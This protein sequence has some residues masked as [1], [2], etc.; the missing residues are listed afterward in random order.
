MKLS[1]TAWALIVFLVII[2]V[3]VGIVEF[4]SISRKDEAVAK[5]WT[6][7]ASALDLR[8]ASVPALVRTIVLYTGRDDETSRKLTADQQAYMAATTVL[9]KATAANEIEMD[10]NRLK[11]QAGQLYAGIQSHYQFTELM[12]NFRTSQEKLGPALTAYNAAVDAYNS[13]IRQFPANIIAM[14]LGF[15]RGAYVG[16]A[17]G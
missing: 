15:D 8:Y 12:D 3:L 5:A 4:N 13:A 10:L 6:P 1:G 2:A 17:G 9:S 11:V 14:I 7:L 16:K